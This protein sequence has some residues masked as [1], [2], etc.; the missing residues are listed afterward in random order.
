MRFKEI[1]IGQKAE[2]IHTITETDIEKFVELTGDDNKLHIDKGFAEK[3]SFRKPVA[4]GMLGASFISTIIGTRIPGDGALWFA[5]NLEFLLPVRVGDTLTVKAEVLKKIERQQIVELKTDVYNQHKQKVIAGYAKVKVVEQ[6]EV[7]EEKLAAVKFPK[8]ALIVGCTGGIGEATAYTLA[9]DG[10][11]IVIHYNRNKEAANRIGETIKK[12]GRKVLLVKADIRDSDEVK[13]MFASIDRHFEGLSVLVN[14]ST[15]KVAN[16]KFEQLEWEDIDKH[17]EINVK[18]SFLL[19]KS[20]VPLM[21]K[22]KYGKIIHITTQAIEYPFSDLLPYITAK[23]A[24]AGFSKSLALDLA[25]K[26]IRVNTVSPGITDTD[27]N[28]DL[29]EKVKLVTAAKTPMNRLAQAQDVANAISYLASERSDFITGETI[30][31][32]GGQMML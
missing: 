6:E 22:H 4:H 28:A 30:R 26:G 17:L 10:F 9:A 31:V 14:S 8:V 20:A 29:P 12:K 7:V 25:K 21:E 5:Q 13:E 27:L 11:D 23:S 16:I 19:L 3:T 15:V 1:V 24:L 32:N 2:V 18:G